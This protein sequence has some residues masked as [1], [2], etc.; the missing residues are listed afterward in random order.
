MRLICLLIISGCLLCSCHS[1]KRLGRNAPAVKQLSQKFGFKITP[2][3]NLALYTEAALWLG[4]PYKYGGN[5][6]KGVDCSGL[7]NNIYSKVYNVSLERTV[8]GI[9]GK[10]CRKVLKSDLKEGNLVFFNTSDKKKGINHIGLF[11]KNG[12]F[13]HATTSRG[14]MVNNLREDYYRK[15]WKQGGKV[16]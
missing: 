9:A 4:T 8:S 6:H 13:I 12:F 11:L 7:V 10:N 3:D 1:N 16:K 14:V 2:K 5:T 15:S